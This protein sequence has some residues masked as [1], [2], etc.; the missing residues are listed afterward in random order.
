M[1]D[2]SRTH[3]ERIF[4]LKVDNWKVKLMAE[5]GSRGGKV[6]QIP[7]ARST[8]MYRMYRRTE[9]DGFHFDFSKVVYM[10]DRSTVHLQD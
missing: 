2:R 5:E 4:V 8:S 7:H 9:C 10:A 3:K 1:E 6:P